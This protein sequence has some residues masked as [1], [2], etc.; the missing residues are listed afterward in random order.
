MSSP[1]LALPHTRAH[2]ATVAEFKTAGELLPTVKAEGLTL[3]QL[4]DWL[5]ANALN[6]SSGDAKTNAAGASAGAGKFS[7]VDTRE[8]CREFAKRMADSNAKKAATVGNGLPTVL[9]VMSAALSDAG[10]QHECLTILR[11]ITFVAGL[12]GCL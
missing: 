6:S 4:T 12:R 5:N 10:V 2:S 8:V 9:K 7:L 3:D 11:N 1:S